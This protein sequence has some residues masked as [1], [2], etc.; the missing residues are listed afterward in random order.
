MNKLSKDKKEKLIMVCLATGGILALLNFFLIGM[1]QDALADVFWT[2]L[3]SGEF[4]F[5]H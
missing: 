2:L 1:Q 5:N 4:M 3:N